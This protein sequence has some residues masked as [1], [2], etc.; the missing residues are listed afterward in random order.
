VPSIQMYSALIATVIV[1]LS[2]LMLQFG[3]GAPYR[4]ADFRRLQGA[5]RQLPRCCSIVNVA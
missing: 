5:S 4:W 3:H 2:L 1:L